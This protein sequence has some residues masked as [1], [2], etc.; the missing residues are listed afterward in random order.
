MIGGGDWSKD[1]LI[2][3]CFKSW[4]K[5]RSSII[6]NQIQRDHGNMCLKLFMVI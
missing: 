3:D 4:S 5:G 1:R 6:R 2:P